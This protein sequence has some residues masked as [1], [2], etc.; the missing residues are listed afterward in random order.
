MTR[1]KAWGDLSPTQRKVVVVGAAAELAVTA[2]ALRDL[3]GRPADGVR[4]PKP[5][6]VASFA[7]QP[8]GPFAYFAVGRR[9]V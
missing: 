4:G 5:L 6:W 1:K 2:W 7:V 3:R 9:R 8:F